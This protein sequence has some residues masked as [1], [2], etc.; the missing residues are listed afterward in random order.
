MVRVKDTN[1]VEGVMLEGIP[2]T[3]YG[4]QPG[5]ALIHKEWENIYLLKE[6]INWSEDDYFEY[7]ST[8]F[9]ELNILNP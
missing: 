7:A 2:F 9:V 3:I 4:T 6:R 8:R 1:R 5:V